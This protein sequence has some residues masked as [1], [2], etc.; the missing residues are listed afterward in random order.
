MS[1]KSQREGHLQWFS[2]EKSFPSRML[3]KAWFLV[4]RIL[5]SEDSFEFIISFKLSATSLVPALTLMIIKFISL[6]LNFHPILPSYWR[7]SPCYSSTSISW[8]SKLDSFCLPWKTVVSTWLIDILFS[9]LV[10]TINFLL[11]HG[12]RQPINHLITKLFWSSRHKVD[13]TL[14]MLRIKSF[15]CYSDIGL[16]EITLFF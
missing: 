15:Y 11:A 16:Y 8:C 2:I 4:A 5:I 1:S 10:S 14:I 7:F 13:S 12:S 9:K 6:I 3:C